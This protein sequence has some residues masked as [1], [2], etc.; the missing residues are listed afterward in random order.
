IQQSTDL[1]GQINSHLSTIEGYNQQ[2]SAHTSHMYA[3]GGSIQFLLAQGGWVGNAN[4][5]IAPKIYR[6]AMG[7]SIGTDTVPAMLTPGEYVV[8]S[9]VAQANAANLTALNQTGRWPGNDNV[10]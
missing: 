2:I 5:N 10:E 6:R 1:L 9:S 3:P 7:G 4:D 8:R